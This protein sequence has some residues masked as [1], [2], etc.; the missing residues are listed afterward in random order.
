MKKLKFVLFIILLLISNLY[1]NTNFRVITYN[2]LKFPSENGAGRLSYFQTVF[3]ESE[4]DILMTQEIEN[5]DGADMLLTTLNANGIQ[6]ARA[7]FV[8]T[9][10]FYTA[11]MLFY[12]TSIATLISQDIIETPR[13]DIAEYVIFIDGN[14]IRFYSCHLKAC[15]TPEDE[16]KRLEEIT[17]LRNHLNNLEEGTEFIIVGDMNFYTSSEPAYQKI[18]ADEGN[19]IGRGQDLSDQVGNWHENYAFREVHS[20]SSRVNFFGGGAG[21]GLDDRFD[22]IFSSYEINNDSGIE[23]IDSSLTY[24]GNDG[25]HFNQ[26]VND[27][28]NAAVPDS[29]A[30]ALYYASDHLP[31][32]AYFVSLDTLC[33]ID[34][35]CNPNSEFSLKVFP[36][37]FCNDIKIE[38]YYDNNNLTKISKINICN[39]KGQLVKKFQ[40]PIYSGTKSKNIIEWNGKDNLGYK[41]KNGIYFIKIINNNKLL[42]A[43]KIV[44]LE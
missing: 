18:I 26:S 3:Q 38:L 20:Q 6:Y 34:E 37:P 35:R 11:N 17:C 14:P 8:L 28:T 42:G 22:F 10:T 13:R 12:K 4:P 24:F 32:F 1:S 29:V 19:N 23:Y 30:D 39:I 44:K 33:T 25:N 15:N 41:I 40:S 36:N 16:Q 43:K 21:G 9:D 31:V 5:E 27:S 2:A 7:E